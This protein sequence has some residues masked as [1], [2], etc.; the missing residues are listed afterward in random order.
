VVERISVIGVIV[1]GLSAEGGTSSPKPKTSVSG[2][3][4]NF[5]LNFAW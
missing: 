2:R 4:F 3:F 5:V 1:C